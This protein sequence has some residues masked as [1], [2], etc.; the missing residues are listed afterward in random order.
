MA[1]SVAQALARSR[2]VGVAR[3]DA[4]L[5]LAQVLRRERAWLIAHD[6]APLAEDD[7][8]RYE[9]L[10]QQRAAGVPLAYLSGEREFRALTFQVSQAVLVP[11]PE[12]EA[13]VE[14]ALERLAALH[15]VDVPRVV[16]LGTGSGVIAL[17]IKHA[18]GVAEVTG[19]DLSA[20]ALQVARGNADRLGLAVA[21][22]EGAWWS[23]V[24]DERFHLAASNPPYIAGDDVH[25]AALAHEPR[26]ALTPE[27][28]GLS[29]LHQIIDGAPE[30]LHANAWLLLEHGHDQAS[31][32]QQR[33]RS[34]GFADL[35]TRRDLAGLQRCTGARWPGHAADPPN[36][37]ASR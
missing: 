24:G 9:A 14:W 15:D 32:V 3:L 5:L 2:S 21:L 10:V 22:R 8:R 33:L 11:R 23:A 28:D 37:G 31:A 27:G 18:H 17:S 12:T 1:L 35:Q 29:A 6:D 36:I 20:P 4:Q 16:D 7:A 13:L 25:L 30:H 19:T 26:L 34:Q